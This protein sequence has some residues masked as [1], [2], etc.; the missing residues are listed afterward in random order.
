MV[1]VHRQRSGNDDIRV[2]SICHIRCLIR[3]RR[4]D[5]TIQLLKRK[6]TNGSATGAVIM[7]DPFTFFTLRETEEMQRKGFMNLGKCSKLKCV[8][9]AILF[10]LLTVP[11]GA[12]EDKKTATGPRPVGMVNSSNGGVYEKGEYGIIFKANFYDQDQLYDGNDKVD[13]TRPVKGQTPGKKCS[14]KSLRQL[15]MTLRAGI[16]ENIDARVIIPFLDKEMKRQSWNND[17]SNDNSGIGDIKLVS[18]YRIWSQKKKDP[19]NLAIGAGVKLPTGSTG[20]ED[21]TGACLPGF[22]QTG[23]GSWDPVVELGAHKVLGRHWLSSYLMY[24]MTTE[25]ELGDRDYEKPDLF[26]YNFGYAYAVSKLFDLQLECNGEI[27]GKATLDGEEQDNTG[28]HIVY[29]SPGLHF[30]FHKGMHFD[31]CTPVPVY[32]DL[33]GTQF[34]EDFRIVAKLAMKF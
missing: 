26:K 7:Q 2:D 28:G 11:A 17:F 29:L 4:R 32:R 23:S 30:K 25:G 3:I 8:V 6:G 10:V 5:H 20:E 34:S 22:L 14:E 15:Q 27:K 12:A 24:Q 19:C 31:V 16:T 9:L 21:D 18:R 33:N 13:F 1:G